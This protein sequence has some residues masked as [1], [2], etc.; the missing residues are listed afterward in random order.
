MDYLSHVPHFNMLFKAMNSEQITPVLQELIRVSSF[1]AKILEDTYAIDS[2]GV[3]TSMFSR[4]ME[5]KYGKDKEQKKRI[6]VKAHAMVGV[7]T[8][9][10]VSMEVTLGNKGDSPQ[11]IPLLEK[12]KEGA[13]ILDV[14][15]D[16]AYS[17][18]ANLEAVTKIGAIPYVPF[19]E[20]AT[21]KAMG[22][23]VWKTIYNYFILHQEEFMDHYHQRSN[24]E[25]VFSMIKRKFGNNVR[26]KSFIGMKNEILAKA[27]V[28]NICCLIAASFEFGISPEL[29][30]GKAKVPVAVI[31]TKND[32]S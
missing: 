17:S 6:W 16:K 13:K 9:T 14:C 2:T 25:S 7:K 24:V 27:V 30:W 11:F 20:N 19:K 4:W 15:A 32:I 10:I 21:G 8:K 3:S 31:G 23:R 18:R 26:S 29:I 22:S 1:P 5:K 12:G 28:H